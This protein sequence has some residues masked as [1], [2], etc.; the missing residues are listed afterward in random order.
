MRRHFHAIGT[1]LTRRS[2]EAKDEVLA[3]TSEMATI[4]EA[5]LADAT[6]EA[7][8][9]RRKLSGLGYAASGKA[10]T[11]LL[12]L[13][14]TIVLVGHVLDQT[15]DRLSGSVPTG[16]T[17]VVGLHDP[18]PGPQRP[19]R[20]AG[21]VR[22]QSPG[23]RQFEMGSSWTITSWSA[24]RPTRSSVPAG[25]LGQWSPTGGYGEAKIDAELEDLGADKA[26]DRR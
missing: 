23:R 16:A 4:A 22:L 13:E 21:G 18:D 8:N 26:P 10:I 12:D 17:R 25:C 9:T 19:H 15:R 7:R 3:I 14:N 1:W 2:D 20:Q 11:A 5:A 6:D 24:T